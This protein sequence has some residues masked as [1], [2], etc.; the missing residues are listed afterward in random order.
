MVYCKKL[1]S[2]EDQ[3]RK[4]IYEYEEDKYIGL[5]ID[6]NKNG[7]IIIKIRNVKKLFWERKYFTTYSDFY[8][9]TYIQQSH[10]SPYP[11]SPHKK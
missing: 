1:N 5:P 9:V 6:F 3:Y 7:C 10:I 8:F 4:T 2:K 11:S